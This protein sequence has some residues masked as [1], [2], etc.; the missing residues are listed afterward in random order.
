MRKGFDVEQPFLLVHCSTKF[1]QFKSVCLLAKF[2]VFG[3]Q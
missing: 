2:F 3:Y 1:V